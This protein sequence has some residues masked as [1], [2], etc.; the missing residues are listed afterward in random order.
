M[1]KIIIVLALMAFVKF[2]HSDV[3]EDGQSAKIELARMLQLQEGLSKY[4]EFHVAAQYLTLLAPQI[5]IYYIEEN[6]LNSVTPD[7]TSKLLLLVESRATSSDKTKFKEETAFLQ[8]FSYSKV[9]WEKGDSFGN[10]S[11]RFD[12]LDSDGKI[13][14]SRWFDRDGFE[15]RED[16]FDKN[17]KLRITDLNFRSDENPRYMALKPEMCDIDDFR[18]GNH[19][20]DGSDIV[21]FSRYLVNKLREGN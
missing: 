12:Y 13:L 14:M 15:L 9:A 21:Q 8:N 20:H 17:G 4:S 2:A 3:G 1:K 7:I 18:H 5:S 10:S 11:E 16:V 19:W 6:D